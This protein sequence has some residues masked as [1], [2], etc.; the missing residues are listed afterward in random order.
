M[1]LDPGIVADAA[2]GRSHHNPGLVMA[3]PVLGPLPS[4]SQS[5][6][7]RFSTPGAAGGGCG[8]APEGGVVYLRGVTVLLRGRGLGW[9]SVPH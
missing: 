8:V 9:G 3:A 6:L 7:Y 4:R 1:A 5:S 2:Q